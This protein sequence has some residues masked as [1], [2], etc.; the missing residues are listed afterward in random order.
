LAARRPV[1]LVL[2]DL[3]WA[4]AASL[5]LVAH[6]LRRPPTG[7]V[8]LVLAYRF[9][10][11]PAE[12]LVAVSGAAREGSLTQLELAALGESEAAELRG[13]IDAHA[14]SDLS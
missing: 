9:N 3:Q 7:P 2:D 5:E 1:V 10:Q 4:D 12:L 8:L 13:D 14:R 11:A 6:L